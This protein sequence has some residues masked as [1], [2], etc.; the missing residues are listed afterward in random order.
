[1]DRMLG[2]SSGMIGFPLRLLA[3][4]NYDKAVAIRGA[5][6]VAL[7]TGEEKIIPPGAKFFLCTVEAMPLERK[8]EFL[9]IDEVQ[10]CADP[11]RGHVFTD[12]VL[13]ARG[14]SETLLLGADTMGSMIR[15]LV[16]GVE[17]MSRPRLSKLTYSGVTKVN[18]L[19]PRSALV[20]FT[21]NDVY[22][23][24][25]LVRRQRGGAAVVLGALSPR[26]RNAQVEMYQN[27]EVDYLVATDAIGMGLNMDLGHVSFAATR[28]FDGNRYRQLSPAELAQTAGRAGR[29]TNDGTFGTTAEIGPLDSE[30]VSRIEN[31]QFDVCRQIYWRNPDIM[32]SSMD[33]LKA[34]LRE[35]SDMKGLVRVREADDERALGEL[36]IDQK[37]MACTTNPDTVSLLW[38]VC[39]IPDFEKEW[40]I[41]HGRMLEQFFNHLIEGGGKLPTDWVADHV[42]RIDQTDGDI[43]ALSNRISRIRT[44]TYISNKAD[45]LDDPVHWQER[46]RDIENSLSD[47]LHERLTQRFVDKRTTLLVSK[48][49]ERQDLV[50]AVRADGDVLIEGQYVGYLQGLRFVPDEAQFSADRQ[51]LAGAAA[52]VIR[53]EIR[54][55]VG[56]MIT[57]DGSD[58]TW[59]CNGQIEWMGENI[60][61]ARRGN[62]ML[63][64]VVDVLFN[65]YMESQDRESLSQCLSKWMRSEQEKALYVLN[66][67][68]SSK[69][70]GAARGLIYQLNEQLGSIARLD[71]HEQVDAL[72]RD[73]RRHLKS[74]GVLIG[75]SIIYMPALLKPAAVAIRARLWNI[76]QQPS[77]NFEPPAPGLITIDIGT[78]QNIEIRKA[79]LKAIGYEVFR[80]SAGTFSVR[81]DM[82]ERIASKAWTLGLEKPFAMDAMLM[83][84]AG[85]GEERTGAI[86]AGI[87]FRKMVKDGVTLYR[88]P[89]P[90]S[91]KNQNSDNK[92]HPAKEAKNPKQVNKKKQ[93][94]KHKQ[95]EK[96]PVIDEDSPFAVLKNLTLAK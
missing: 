74:L 4:E 14:L 77:Q 10:M 44:W 55:R 61:V 80:D 83:S 65:D 36:S 40:T 47:A 2:H 59:R 51:A 54:R 12:R 32:T 43:D 91:N 66:K 9:A 88:V 24:A 21:V 73:D 46:T 71:A 92:R 93:P 13:H 86:L 27:G 81:L 35:P 6:Q 96:K 94:H 48:L 16:P 23:L 56:V 17:F 11:D 31:H 90:G 79:F 84:L 28:K 64:P 63:N 67:A 49:R 78:G 22:A 29:H 3:R 85:A 72:T 82:V 52:K 33:E 76:W 26:T 58:F 34:S 5:A 89:R 62:E 53:A 41:G 70:S 7:V 95:A 39:Q 8:V 15:R 37:I 60:A 45:W 42:S 57:G 50:A 30:T 68:L 75:R 25:E 38:N 69:I 18:R 19:K 20:A 1:M 87:G